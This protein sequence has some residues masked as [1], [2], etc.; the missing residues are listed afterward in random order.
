MI[1][2]I[3]MLVLLKVICDVF[4]G[5]SGGG[6]VLIFIL[7]LFTTTYFLSGFGFVGTVICTL[8]LFIGNRLT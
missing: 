6:M 4:K 1:S 3:I 2:L 8:T 7:A 5:T